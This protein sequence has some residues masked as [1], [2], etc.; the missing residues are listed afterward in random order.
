MY[1][2]LP[3]TF[4]CNGNWEALRKTHLQFYEHHCIVRC[5]EIWHFMYQ[6][7]YTIFCSISFYFERKMNEEFMKKLYD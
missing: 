7:V 4:I 6:E 2:L 1:R 5:T 3:N